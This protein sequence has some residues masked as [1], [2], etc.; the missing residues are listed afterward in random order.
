MSRAGPANALT[1]RGLAASSRGGRLAIVLH[2]GGQHGGQMQAT[3]RR[4]ALATEYCKACGRCITACAHHCITPGSEVHPATGLAP[5]VLDLERCSGCGLC[6]DACPEP[7]GLGTEGPCA[8]APA[9]PEPAPA[10]AD[11][12]DRFLDLP[13]LRPL[14]VKGTYASA[15]GALLA[16]C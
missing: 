9:R 4:P 14:V 10:A 5:V 7:H 2:D 16:G 13:A 8:D 3:R 15:I 1:Q 12:P 11:E 6:I